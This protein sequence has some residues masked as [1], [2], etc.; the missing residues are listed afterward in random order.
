MAAIRR[1]EAG[2]VQTRA[3]GATSL[4]NLARPR[5]RP[6]R[7][8]PRRRRRRTL[9]SS[10]I[11]PVTPASMLRLVTISALVGLSRTISPTWRMQAA[12]NRNTAARSASDCGMPPCRM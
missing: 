7:A 9:E 8:V 5:P 1:I 11:Q 12:R 2:I 4:A 10:A 6:P 3:A